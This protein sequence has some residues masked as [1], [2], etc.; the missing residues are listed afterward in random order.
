MN[1]M[2]I[3]LSK[4]QRLQGE[5]ELLK[6]TELLRNFNKLMDLLYKDKY[7]LF[8]N[9]YTDDLTEAAVNQAWADELGKWRDW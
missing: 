7:G 9:D 5:L 8:M 4:Y 3:P 6:N 2:Q 1:T